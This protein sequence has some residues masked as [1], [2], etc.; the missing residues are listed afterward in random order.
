MTTMHKENPSETTESLCINAA[1]ISNPKITF[2]G[3]RFL[4][5][6]WLKYFFFF[7][8][9]VSV[10]WFVASS[11]LYFYLKHAREYETIRFSEVLTLPLRIDEHRKEM[12]SF[13]IK[14][15]LRLLSAEDGNVSAGLRLLRLG[16][17]R[18]PTHLEARKI[19]AKTLASFAPKMALQM[20]EEGLYAYEGKFD[21]EYMDLT[22]KLM[23]N[24]HMEDALLNLTEQLIHDETI[25]ENTKQELIK[26]K[27]S[28]YIARGQFD[29]ATEYINEYGLGHSAEGFVLLAR[30][31]AAKGKIANQINYLKQAIEINKDNEH[32]FEIINEISSAYLKLGNADEALKYAFSI[33]H[34]LIFAIIHHHNGDYEAEKVQ[35]Q[36]MVEAQGHKHQARLELAT[37]AVET[38]NPQLAMQIYELAAIHA[39]QL[40]PF[41]LSLIKAKLKA[42]DYSGA[43]EDIEVMFDQNPY[44]LERQKPLLQGFRALCAY[45]L[46]RPDLGDIYIIDFTNAYKDKPST[47]LYIAKELNKVGEKNKA[48]ELAE[49]ALQY[50]ERHPGLLALAVYLSIEITS[51]NHL[52]EYLLRFLELRKPDKEF[53]KQALEAVNKREYLANHSIDRKQLLNKLQM[54]IDD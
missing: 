38:A 4:N 28:I 9:L 33:G 45:A 34:H 24:L 53:A 5:Q 49:I 26:E 2:K 12:G 50:S 52:E 36:G 7:I 17:I 11:A 8:L 44:W 35:I 19:Y 47:I 43:L 13:H 1:M 48:L 41:L 21:V 23:K 54:L 37:Y 6:L 31:E 39:D 20:L 30:I 42:G 25:G 46:Y 40:E 22:I 18:N 10:T 3:S 27:I 32:S 15:G 29:H 16:L 51:S 14:K